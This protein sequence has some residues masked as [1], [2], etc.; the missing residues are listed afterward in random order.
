[1]PSQRSVDVNMDY[2]VVV[3]GGGL[4]GLQTTRLLAMRGLKVV[5]L[6]QHLIGEVI[7]L[8]G[9]FVQEAFEELPF[10]QHLFG[11]GLSRITIH[12]PG[13]NTLSVEHPHYRLYVAD[14]P[15]LLEWMAQE[16]KHTG[17]T[18]LERHRLVE[19]LP[20]R[21]G[22][23]L[24]VQYPGGD[25]F[26]V[27]SRFVLGADGPLSRVA[28]CLGLPRYR[29]FLHGIEEHYKADEIGEGVVHWYFG[30]RLAPG[31][32]A[33]VIPADGG[34]QVGLAGLVRSGWSPARALEGFVEVVRPEFNLGE[35]TFRRG[36][37]IPCAGP[38]PVL[39]KERTMLVGDAAGLV[40]PLT[41][42]GIHFVL[43]QSRRSAYLVSRYLE[44]GDTRLFRRPLPPEVH[45]RM[46]MKK[47][48]RRVYELGSKDWLLDLG[49]AVV[50]AVLRTRLVK[51]AFYGSKRSRSR[52][53]MP[54]DEEL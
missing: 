9:L 28:A 1:V 26:T 31:Y 35:M 33:W 42:G 4:A 3:I 7:Q 44:T 32:L 20:T 54:V 22:M 23:E 45:R 27:T 34:Y 51:R 16:A 40:S 38:R 37:V 10:P 5:C 12:A 52:R 24:Q 43:Q 21:S 48:V 39:V 41:S 19:L 8:T 36:G 6:E 49:M 50:P 17:A 11:S 47:L 25:P 30:R 13:G 18:I 53:W 46:V 15:A 29:R 2:D 14:M